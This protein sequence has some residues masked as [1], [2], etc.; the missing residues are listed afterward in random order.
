[1]KILAAIL[2]AFWDQKTHPEINQ[3]IDQILNDFS[4]IAFRY[5]VLQVEKRT[6]ESSPGGSGALCRISVP[7][8]CPR[9][10]VAQGSILVAQESI[11]VPQ[12]SIL[13]DFS[14]VFQCFWPATAATA[15]GNPPAIRRQSAG[16]FQHRIGHNAPDP[17]GE[18]SG[19][20]FST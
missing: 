17:P 14:M 2:D 19:V 7:A 5:R 15:A 11:L 8:D 12:E 20:L 18:D 6:P 16:N 4:L 3:K 13:S 10:L 9:I 1:M